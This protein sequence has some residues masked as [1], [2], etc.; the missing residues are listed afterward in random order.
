MKLEKDVNV[1]LQWRL[2]FTKM[3]L[4]WEIL[5]VLFIKKKL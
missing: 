5:W 2:F 4:L 1:M 3:Q